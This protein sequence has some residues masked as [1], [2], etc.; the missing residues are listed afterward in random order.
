MTSHQQQ[1]KNLCLLQWNCL[2]L[3]Q[4]KTELFDLSKDYDVILL[5]E[6]WLNPLH[7]FSLQGFV[8]ARNDEPV[9][10]GGGTAICIRNSHPLPNGDLNCH[11]TT[12]S[13]SFSCNLGDHLFCTFVEHDLLVVND[14]SPT[15]LNRRNPTN[16]LCLDLTLVSPHLYNICSWSVLEDKY[17]SDHYPIASFLGIPPPDSSFRSHRP[18]YRRIFPENWNDFRE[19]LSN[20]SFDNLPADTSAAAKYEALTSSI[21]LSVNNY[22]PPT[23]SSNK[24]PKSPKPPWWNEECSLA[25]SARKRALKNFRRDPNLYSELL[26]NTHTLDLFCKL[27]THS[28]FQIAI[29]K[30]LE[31]P[32]NL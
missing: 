13:S 29:Y 3:R 24:R 8:I 23:R 11:N 19:S 5:C 26:S 9:G 31:K 28:E 1:P 17:L 15:Y 12:W 4:R 27:F 25:E 16:P 10:R 20:F 22:I 7:N 21:L 14:G 30:C 2:S 32:D 6:T 18:N